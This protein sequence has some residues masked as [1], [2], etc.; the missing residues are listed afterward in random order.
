MNL[1]DLAGRI[2]C[3]NFLLKLIFLAENRLFVLFF[4]FFYVWNTI[5]IKLRNGL[6]FI[7]KKKSLAD[8]SM[9]IE[10]FWE[11]YYNPP[12]FEIKENYVVFDVWAH[13]WFF[14]IYAAKKAKK[15][16]V[17]SFEP[18]PYNYS[19]LKDNIKL[20]GISNIISNQCAVWKSE[21]MVDIFEYE[22]HNW[23]HSLYQRKEGQKKY[24]IKET[25]IE[26]IMNQYKIEKIDFLKLDCEAAEYEI[27]FNMNE[28]IL[29]KIYLIS[30]EIHEDIIIWKT[31]K[32]MMEFLIDHWFFVTRKNWY[33]YWINNENIKI[34]H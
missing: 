21:W 9:L 16:K 5:T 14:S 10:I 2:F 19:R 6:K 25:T 28:K 7:L 26:S 1:K 30:M 18:M 20:N 15:W 24:V 4:R 29:K 3:F 33:I 32:L 17:F 31:W 27:L 23:C 34:K 8:L 22:C 11:E 12:F 13:V